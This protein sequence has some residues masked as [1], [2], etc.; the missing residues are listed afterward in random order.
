MS[1]LIPE[2]RIASF[3]WKTAFMRSVTMRYNKQDHLMRKVGFTDPRL[4]GV[5][6]RGSEVRPGQS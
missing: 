2:N 6:G 4:V 5:K 3:K 1:Y